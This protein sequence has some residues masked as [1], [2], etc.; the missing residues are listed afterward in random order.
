[1]SGIIAIATLVV[2]GVIIA[3]ILTHPAGTAAAS[4]GVA[5]IWGSSINGLLGQPSKKY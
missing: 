5:N 2:G 1:M 3:D 4:S